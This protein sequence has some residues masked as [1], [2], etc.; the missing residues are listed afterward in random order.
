[1][2]PSSRLGIALLCL[3][4]LT[5][6]L[7]AQAPTAAT[8]PTVV[9]GDNLVTRHI[10][11]IPQSIADAVGR[12]TESRS[13][14]FRS[15]H[16]SRREMLIRTRFADTTQIHLVRMPL[17]M[18]K[19]LTF[20]P[21]SVAT[22]W[23]PNTAD[24]DYFLFLKD[25]GGNEFAQI[26]RFDMASGD[27]TMLTDGKSRNSG[28]P[29]A[30][31]SDRV[32]YTSTRRN[33][34]DSDFYVVSP[35]DPK[36]DKL[37][38]QSDS[39]GWGALDWSAEDSTI[40]IG[41][42]ISANESH[43]F[44]M[45]AKTGERKPLTPPQTSE[46]KVAW[47]GGQFSADGKRVYTT[48]D[49]DSEFA[50]LA[51]IDVDSKQVTILT[52]DVKWDVEEFA[53][54]D[55]GRLMAYV[56]NEDGV[57]VLHLMETA[58]RKELP[59]P[60]LP[61]GQIGS[62]DWHKNNKDL[63]L[64]ISSARAPSDVYVVDVTA[65]KVERW[66]ESETA[67]LNTA[68][69]VEPELI[70]WK[71]FDG[72]SI[73]GFLYRPNPSKY[74]GKRPVMISI[75]GGPEGQYRPA[76]LGAFNYYLNELGV[77][78]IFPNVRGSSGYGKSFLKMDNGRLREDSVKDIGA[79]LD[80]VSSDE[81]LDAG[82]IAV[83]GGS[84]GGYMTLAVSFHYADKIRCA[85]DSVGI[86]NFVSFLQNTEPYRQ[87]LR[88]AEYGD[89]RDPEMRDFLL[90]IAPLTNV[91]KIKKP[92]FVIQGANDPRVP[93]SE[94]DQMVG[95]LETQGTPVWYLLAKDEG[96]GFARKKNYEFQFYTSIAF[97]KKYLLN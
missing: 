89:E 41:R 74:P 84:Y 73:S 29:F 52:P 39:P 92:L 24:G 9:P 16:P 55:D 60:K 36:S 23:H 38:S 64:T 11:P 13:A 47:Q 48:T 71:S 56:L 26:F 75:H 25:L 65:G 8:Q 86:S 49:Q 44:L 2:T 94:A 4:I 20:F 77:A 32:V 21:D 91:G 88:R 83:S 1:M 27:V 17:G 82:R 18:R 97:V 87:D 19:Q 35:A 37:L 61:A 90:K 6:P 50:R 30:R 12:Y 40:L 28:G 67:G 80:W 5:A 93:K 43:L 58:T 76:F 53:V 79:L 66:T 70:R 59:L 68:T 22:A 33:R 72:R 69:F 3:C 51:A 54:S 10:P 95:A 15:W 78:V 45:D 46:E 42:Y 62:L 31:K 63:A 7:F 85:I 96:H 14:G 34:R 57:G 81:R